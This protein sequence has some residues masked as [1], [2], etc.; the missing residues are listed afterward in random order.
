M[1]NCVTDCK[2]ALS[3][4]RRRSLRKC[5]VLSSK[6]PSY[7]WMFEGKQI[8]NNDRSSFGTNCKANAAVLPVYVLYYSPDMGIKVCVVTIRTG[9][10]NNCETKIVRNGQ[11]RYPF[12]Y[13]VFITWK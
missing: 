10:Q 8:E 1:M 2:K 12:V 3:S 11:V 7:K 9:I 4:Q 6:S 13:I 5:F